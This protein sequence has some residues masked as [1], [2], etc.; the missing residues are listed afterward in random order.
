[1]LR[2]ASIWI[3][4]TFTW[5]G[6]A[7][8]QSGCTRRTLR[9]A[10]YPYV[11]ESAEMFLKIEQNFEK[12]HPDVR[13]EFVDLE[14]DYYDGG[15]LTA[16]QSKKA[17]VDV[18]EVDTVFLQDLVEN[19]LIEALPESVLKPDTTFL[20]V[21][22]NAAT[23]NG[24]V[25]GVPHWVCS[26]FL[27]FRT[28][29]PDANRLSKVTK[30]NELEQIL[31]HPAAEEGALLADI[32]GKSTL[33]EVYLSSL[34]DE[35]QTADGAMAHLGDPTKL[36]AAASEIP[37]R[38][39]VL[40]PGGMNHNSKYHLYGQFYSRQFA[41]CKARAN[42]SYSEKLYYVGDEFLHGVR[43]DESGIG[44]PGKNEISVIGAPLADNR[45][46]V[47][48]WVDVV[49]LRAGLAGKTR[50]DAMDFVSEYTGETFNREMLIPSDGHA[51]RYLLP[52][53]LALYTN[54]TILK[55]AP[56]YSQFKEIMQDAVTVTAS[57]LNDRLQVIGKTLNGKVDK[58]PY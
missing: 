6:L 37:N 7:F 50:R 49:C 5:S 55:A 47:L 41:H 35:Y 15:L 33:G 12:T 24:T 34:V 58:L 40:C 19:K 44:D 17:K 42:I 10:A 31:D 25:F 32:S 22:S 27:F 30:L 26:N 8:C 46:K 9:V 36:D 11:P 3:L 16:L 18:V 29:D 45:H 56:L 51:P 23:L 28:N 14:A 54:A 43:E 21:A 57:H 53:R 2:R 38:L 4:V 48:A 20:P 39:F 52:A 13:L 1:M